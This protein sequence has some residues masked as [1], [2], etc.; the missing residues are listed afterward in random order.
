M[1]LPPISSG[2]GGIQPGTPT[3]GTATAGNAS[4]S[5][6]F[7]AP[8]YLGKPTGTTYTATSTPS[9]IT[10]TSSTSPITVSGL[11]NGTAYTFKVK[12]GNGVATSLESASSNSV[13][14]VAP[15]PSPTPPSPT[16]PATTYYASACCNGSQITASSQVS[17][18]AALDL[19]ECAGGYYASAT[20]TSGYPSVTCL[21]YATGCC[22]SSG[23]PDYVVSATG[24]TA[25]LAEA[26]LSCPGTISGVIVTTT[27]QNRPTCSAP[28]P[29]PTPPAPT[30]PAC[31][32]GACQVSDGG[33]TYN[34][35]YN[36]GLC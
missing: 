29:A 21:Y 13:S 36:C 20:S 26:A 24:F 31:N 15:A 35:C 32:C 27:A 7:T 22:S 10:G 28:A 30:P 5:V 6:T 18:Q 17:A 11:S 9:D 23:E 12:L 25:G 2:S 14:P 19:L 33:E 3:I 4:A 16:P 1:P 34:L 8:S